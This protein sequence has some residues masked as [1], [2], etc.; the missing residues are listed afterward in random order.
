MPWCTAKNW[1]LAVPTNQNWKFYWQLYFLFNT[2]YHVLFPSSLGSYFKSVTW[3]VTED[4]LTRECYT[5]K[6]IVKIHATPWLY[7]VT[8]TII[9]TSFK[10]EVWNEIMSLSPRHC[11]NGLHTETAPSRW[12]VA[13]LNNEQ[14]KTVCSFWTTLK[15]SPKL[16]VF[17]SSALTLNQQARFLLNINLCCNPPRPLCFLHF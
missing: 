2:M 17:M 16:P 8:P 13:Y 7:G 1:A 10:A 9:R 12:N 3:D 5:K 11:V 14:T 4:V 15:L 6:K